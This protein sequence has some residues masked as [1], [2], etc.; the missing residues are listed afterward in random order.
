M[1]ISKKS[2]T[3]IKNTGT[4]LVFAGTSLFFF[5][6]TILVPLVYG[7]YLTFTDWNGI[8]REK[9]IV[10]LENYIKAFGDVK[11]WQSL[12]LTIIFTG[13][14]VLLVNYIAF[15]LARLVTKGVRFQNFY[16]ASFFTPN[17]IGGVVLGYI[18]QFIFGRVLVAFGKSLDIGF[19]SKSWL[20]DTKLAMA[21]LILVTVWQYSGY[22]MLIY[23]AGLMNVPKELLEAGRIDGCD[24]KACR[25]YIV[26]PMM[27]SSFI[28]CIFLTITRCFMTYDLNFSLTEGNPFGSTVMASMYVYRKAFSEKNYGL[29]QTE[30]ILLFVVCAFVSLMQ[31]YFTKK[32]EVQ[33]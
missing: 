24:E 5:V 26:M 21:A 32:K 19:L 9:N 16:R 14:A 8:S 18:W 7:V 20:S 28:I 31:I 15:H 17:L 29:G 4:F 23:I 2:R 6:M 27:I 33:A 12:L 1:S 25:K 22:M 30:A 10:G 3:K 13:I 11:F